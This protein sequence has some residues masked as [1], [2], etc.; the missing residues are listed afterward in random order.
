MKSP[1]ARAVLAGQLSPSSTP[2]VLNHFFLGISKLSR[3]YAR[4]CEMM[5]VF[6]ATLHSIIR[7]KGDNPF[8]RAKCKSQA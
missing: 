4:I 1:P 6:I 7:F 2:F 5:N 8:G 3:L